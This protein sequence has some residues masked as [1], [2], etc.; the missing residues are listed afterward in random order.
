VLVLLEVAGR[1][2]KLIAGEH[3]AICDECVKICHGIMTGQL[4]GGLIDKVMELGLDPEEP[5][6]AEGEEE[7]LGR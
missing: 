7:A 2:R 4:K 6:T 3:G 5:R 1:V